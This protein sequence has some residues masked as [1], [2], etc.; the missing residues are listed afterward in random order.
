MIVIDQQLSLQNT[1]LVVKAR[2]KNVQLFKVIIA[3]NMPRHNSA[4][5][6]SGL[7]R[8]LSVTGCRDLV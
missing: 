7:N 8:M 5:N 3:D 1:R 4:Q 6:L 2:N